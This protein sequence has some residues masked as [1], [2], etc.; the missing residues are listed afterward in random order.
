MIDIST[1]LLELTNASVVVMFAFMLASSTAYFLQQIGERETLREVY[2]ES[3][4]SFAATILFFGLFV[5][6]AIVWWT[7]HVVDHGYHLGRPSTHVFN[8]LLVVTSLP[9]LWGG[10]CWMRAVL[11]LKLGP[12]AW[13]FVALFSIA[14][15]FASVL[16]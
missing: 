6:Q 5:R 2:A 3:K 13:V 14:C 8:V 15:G 4:A 9:I 12:A 1:S 10:V 7:R 16:V 11:P